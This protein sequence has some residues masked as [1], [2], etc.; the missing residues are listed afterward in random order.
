MLFILIFN[1]SKA[2]SINYDKHKV[3]TY[4][5]EQ[6]KTEKWSHQIF[7]ADYIS[8]NNCT[9]NSDKESMQKRLETKIEQLI[10]KIRKIADE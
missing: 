10:S 3:I 5:I 7:P 1:F 2:S 8:I 9:N 4:I 6:L